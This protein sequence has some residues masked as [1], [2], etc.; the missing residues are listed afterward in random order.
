[1]RIS[2][3]SRSYGQPSRTPPEHYIILILFIAFM[4]GLSVYVLRM[5]LIPAADRVPTKAVIT[6]IVVR[7]SG[8]LLVYDVTVRYMAEGRELESVIRD[9]HLRA[10]VGD[11]I[12]IYYDRT[13][14]YR[15]QQSMPGMFKLPVLMVMYPL[16]ILI[17]ILLIEIPNRRRRRKK[18]AADPPA[19]DPPAPEGK[20]DS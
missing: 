12:S 1:M 10:H 20:E 17:M 9:Y 4:A 5:H 14:P 2:A 16:G 3:A 13:D 19:D 15:V 18:K 7:K 6:E 11:T 8:N